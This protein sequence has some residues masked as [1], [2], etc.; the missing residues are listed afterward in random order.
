MTHGERSFKVAL[1]S[2]YHRTKMLVSGASGDDPRPSQKNGPFWPPLGWEKWVTRQCH[3]PSKLTTGIEKLSFGMFIMH[4][5][6][7]VIHLLKY[8]NIALVVP[9]E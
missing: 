2:G 6:V 9:E 5:N 7:Y 4:I 1:S 8:K 3:P